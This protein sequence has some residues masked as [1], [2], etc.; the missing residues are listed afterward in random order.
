MTTSAYHIGDLRRLTAVFTVGGTDTD[1]SALTF[2]M[3][4]PDGTET[5]YLLGTDA[6][7]VKDSTGNYHVDWPIAK[8]RRHHYTWIGTGAA[9]EA[10]QGEFYAVPRNAG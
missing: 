4:E 6:E 3:R 5:S 2:T 1:P 9:A 10:G 7:L 8:A